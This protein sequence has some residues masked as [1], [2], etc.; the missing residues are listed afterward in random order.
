[1]ESFFHRRFNATFYNLIHVFIFQEVV[2]NILRQDFLNELRDI[3][4]VNSMAVANSEQKSTILHKILQRDEG[5][6]VCFVLFLRAEPAAVA[7]GILIYTI[8]FLFILSV[9]G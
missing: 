9:L 3:M 4:A 8:F 5:V 6:L 1:M 7:V 2:L